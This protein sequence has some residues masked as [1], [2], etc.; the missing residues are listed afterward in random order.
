MV[1]MPGQLSVAVGSIQLPIV[2]QSGSTSLLRPI[3][4]STGQLNTVGGS[5]STTVTVNEHVA[6]LPLAS[7]TWKVF[8]VTPTG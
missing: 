6:V 4:K 2:I 1:I 7:V 5:L 8:V 3:V